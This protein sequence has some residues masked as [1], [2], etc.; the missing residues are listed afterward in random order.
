MTGVAEKLL[1][2]MKIVSEG[3]RLEKVRDTDFVETSQE[4]EEKFELFLY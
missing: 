4:R 1:E 3:E 2:A